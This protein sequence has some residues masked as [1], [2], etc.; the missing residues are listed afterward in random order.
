[1]S[2]QRPLPDNTHNR[3]TSMP[4]SGIR[5]QNLSSRVATDSGLRPCGHWDR[6]YLVCI[7]KQD[8]DIQR[9]KFIWWPVIIQLGV[10]CVVQT[11]SWKKKNFYTPIS[12]QKVHCQ[13][14]TRRFE[15]EH[16]E[17]HST[18]N[19]IILRNSDVL[20][21]LLAECCLCCGSPKLCFVCK[22]SWKNGITWRSFDPVV[23]LPWY[24]YVIIF[25]LFLSSHFHPRPP[26]FLSVTWY[27]NSCFENSCNDS[28]S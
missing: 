11:H 27:S 24:I 19:V 17:H 12:S 4:P 23:F 7:S 18:S 22:C 25:L 6:L 1:M 2:S 9:Q 3:Q 15:E 14:D 8:E 16:V 28:G 20:I 5:T 21:L 26:L 10:P 13:S